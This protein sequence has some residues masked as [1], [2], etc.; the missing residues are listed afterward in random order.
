MI[1]VW[2]DIPYQSPLI[3]G[4]RKGGTMIFPLN[5]VTIFFIKCSEKMSAHKYISKHWQCYQA[6]E[7][8]VYRCCDCNHFQCDHWVLSLGMYYC[9]VWYKYFFSVYCWVSFINSYVEMYQ[10]NA[11]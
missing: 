1:C 10:G 7:L 2:V 6:V 8:T 5:R 9:D 11:I 4:I 3:W